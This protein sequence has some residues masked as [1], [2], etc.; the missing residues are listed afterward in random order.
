MSRVSAPRQSSLPFFG[1]TRSKLWQRNQCFHSIRSTPVTPRLAGAAHSG[2]W[3]PTD[4][5]ACPGSGSTATVVVREISLLG[6]LPPGA[7]GCGLAVIYHGREPTP[8][9]KALPNHSAPQIASACP[10]VLRILISVLADA[11][12]HTM[13]LLSE[14]AAAVASACTPSLD[15]GDPN[16]H[17]FEDRL[18]CPEHLEMVPTSCV[19]PS[20]LSPT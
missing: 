1:C 4:G 16:H 14:S 8:F 2:F 3:L 17:C 20:S 10:N 11:G 18:Q 15:G 19:F 7:C 13:L 6:L 5:P 9:T 12:S